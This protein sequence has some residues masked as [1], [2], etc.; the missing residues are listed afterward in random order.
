MHFFD[1]YNIKTADKFW[2]F[3]PLALFR[4]DNYYR[5][6]PSSNMTKAQVFNSMTLFVVYV[7]IIFILI[8]DRLGCIYVPIIALLAI[9]V[10]YFIMEDDRRTVLRQRSNRNQSLSSVLPS[11]NKNNQ[12]SFVGEGFQELSKDPDDLKKIDIIQD[13]QTIDNTD[14]TDNTDSI[15]TE[16]TNRYFDLKMLDIQNRNQNNYSGQS[17][18]AHW[19]YSTPETC[20]ENNAMCFPYEDL[21]HNRYNP[22]NDLPENLS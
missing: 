20:K 4:N 8:T 18:L 16:I 3:D 10:I 15:D 17:K 9:I 12:S 19:L 7:S 2:L 22:Q 21:K 6:I 11:M 1:N 14:N 13:N 5:I